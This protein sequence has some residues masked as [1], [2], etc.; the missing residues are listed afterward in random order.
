MTDDKLQYVVGA[1]TSQYERSMNRIQT[2]AGAVSKA[3][4][5]GFKTSAAAI[6]AAFAGMAAS[7]TKS[8]AELER[9]MLRTQ[10]II[11]A[12]GNAAG[13]EA[14]ELLKFAKELDLSTLGN[15]DAILSAINTMQ[16]FKSVSGDTFKRS[17]EL[18]QDLSEV[19]GTDI[20]SSALQLGKALEDPIKG[21]SAL[22]RVGV[23]FTEDQKKMIKSMVEANKTVEAQG[24]ILDTLAKQVGGAAKGAAG[25]LSGSVDTLDYRWTEFKETLASSTGVINNTAWAIDKL[26]GALKAMSEYLSGPTAA[27]A[28]EEDI[29]GM[30]KAFAKN[31]NWTGYVADRLRTKLEQ[32]KAQLEALKAGDEQGADWGTRPET[33]EWA[34]PLGEDTAA[35]EEA[36]KTLYGF[37]SPDEYDAQVKAYQDYQDALVKMR[38]DGLAAG[39]EAKEEALRQYIEQSNREVEA[40][41]QKEEAKKEMQKAAGLAMVSNT[42]MAF[43]EFGKSSTAAFEAFKAISISET[44]VNTYAAATAAYKAMAGIPVVGPALGVAAAAAAVAYG[45]AQ[46]SAISAMTPGS[47]GSAAGTTSASTTT[48]ANPTGTQ[49]STGLDPAYA[50]EDKKGSLT[51]NVE[52]DV[53]GDE[54]W[55]DQLAEKINWAI[56]DRDVVLNT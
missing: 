30:E 31:P 5:I 56:A 16:T 1:Q 15:R 52:G 22:S 46:V 54:T 33:P 10:S 23:S 40:E 3:I 2:K 17:I 32:A 49:A 20:T 55:I 42:K 19:L 8:F 27:Q 53:I 18:S 48:N 38:Q 7:G 44:V 37:V 24:V 26:S 25:G 43:A 6:V 12:T 9:K 45:M 47:K 29:A 21:I 51:I 34:K 36:K 50:S 11:K 13:L 4:G 14:T 39:W 35:N 41:R 28:L